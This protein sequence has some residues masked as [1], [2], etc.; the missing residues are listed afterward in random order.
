AKLRPLGLA[1]LD[2]V[3][4]EDTLAGGD[5]RLDCSCSK[6]LA[7]RNQ[8]DAGRIPAGIDCG[9]SNELA[10]L[11]KAGGRGFDLEMGGMAAHGAGLYAACVA[12]QVSLNASWPGAF[13]ALKPVNRMDLT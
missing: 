13:C 10:H 9:L 6:G 1:F 3:L 8:G 5:D 4:T 11:G 7:D 2:P 12:L